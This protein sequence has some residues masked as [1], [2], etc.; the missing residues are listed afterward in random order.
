MNKFKKLLKEFGF[1]QKQLAL[2]LGKSQN[3]ISRWCCGTCQPQIE[4]I[5]KIQQ[6]LNV[7]FKLLLHSFIEKIPM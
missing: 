3:L 1:T 5:I 7:D 4:D 2:K 6:L